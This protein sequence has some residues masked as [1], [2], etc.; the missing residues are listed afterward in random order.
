MLLMIPYKEITYYT[1]QR[2][3]KIYVDAYFSVRLHD[4]IYAVFLVRKELESSFPQEILND[5]ED[6]IV[7][8]G[9]EKQAKAKEIIEALKKSIMKA[10][11]LISEGLRGIHPSHSLVRSA[12]ALGIIPWALAKRR[13]E[14]RVNLLLLGKLVKSLLEELEIDKARNPKGK[15]THWIPLRAIVKQGRIEFF[16]LKNQNPGY[17]RIY[18]ILYRLDKGFR[19]E[20]KDIVNQ[21][22]SGM[23]YSGYHLV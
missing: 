14:G 11:K 20:I 4:P 17:T 7:Y 1:K 16:S 3:V 5:R 13:I 15:T 2:V 6:I 18:N 23:Q 12:I 8:I 9:T 22:I 19:K 10:E 21:N